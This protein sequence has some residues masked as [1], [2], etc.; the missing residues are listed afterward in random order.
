MVQN[1]LLREGSSAHNVLD[2]YLKSLGFPIAPVAQMWFDPWARS[3]GKGKWHHSN[4][5][6]PENSRQRSLV[7]TAYGVERADNN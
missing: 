6:C 2:G 4:I 7:A 3:T 5:P 1:T